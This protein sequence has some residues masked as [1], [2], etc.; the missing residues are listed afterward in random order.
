L[1]PWTIAEIATFALG[2]V[3]AFAGDKL[4]IPF[5]MYGG[6]SL[7]GV[8]AFLIGMEAAIMRRIVLGSRRYD[9][10][11]VGF[12]AYAQGVQFM[13]VGA[14]LIGVSFLAYFD[15][16]GDLFLQLVRRPWP[17]LLTFGIYCLMQAAIAIGG[18]EEEK[19][20]PRWI[21]IMNLFASRL[22]PGV[23]LVVIGFGAVALGM[24]D[25]TAPAVFDKLG[26]GFL[27]MLYGI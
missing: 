21:V 1:N 4:S 9:E 16:G 27:E 26:G 12:A 18:Y 10:T 17:V 3:L 11:Y 8:A 20:G 14:F 25:L 13:I 6:I 19:Q 15:T 5:L 24:I 2:F 22:L 7:F 23:I